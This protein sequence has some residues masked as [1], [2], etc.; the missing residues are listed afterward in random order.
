MVT[1]ELRDIN[2]KNITVKFRKDWN[3]EHFCWDIDVENIYVQI[4]KDL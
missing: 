1:T 3:I 4:Q 2:L